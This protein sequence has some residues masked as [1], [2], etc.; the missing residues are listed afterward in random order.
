MRSAPRANPTVTAMA[1][2]YLT[3]S[4]PFAPADLEATHRE[5]ACHASQYTPEQQATVLRYLE[6]G[7]AGAVRL[8]PWVG[9]TAWPLAAPST[10]PAAKP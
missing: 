1:E 3:V 2:R 6:H 7:W 5:F 10:A 9:A 8:R 4:V